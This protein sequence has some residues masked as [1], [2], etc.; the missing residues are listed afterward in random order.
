[1]QAWS[2]PAEGYAEGNPQ[3]EESD[4]GADD[5]DENDGNDGVRQVVD[6]DQLKATIR[7]LIQSELKEFDPDEDS[8][9]ATLIKKT[10]DSCPS[11]LNANAIHTPGNHPRVRSNLGGAGS[12]AATEAASRRI[13]GQGRLGTAFVARERVEGERCPAS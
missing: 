9:V 4:I 3:L 7:E 2:G 1:M 10:V 6:K 5:D 12:R 8:G 11:I 13:E